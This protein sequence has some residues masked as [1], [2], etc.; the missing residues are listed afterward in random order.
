MDFEFLKGIVPCGTS[1]ASHACTVCDFYVLIQNIINF[2]LFMLAPLATLAAVYIAFLFLFSGGSPAKIT[3]AK[4]K[5]WLVVI[6]IFWVLG[7]W[8][9]LNTIINL[10]ANPSAFPWPWNKPNCEVSQPSSTSDGG[11]SGGGDAS[12]GGAFGGAG[13]SGTWEDAIQTD[14]P[15]YQA[16]DSEHVGLEQVNPGD[17]FSQAQIVNPTVTQIVSQADTNGV[18]KNLV[19][20]IIQAESSG[21]TNAIHLDKDGQSSYGLMQVR[22]DT[23][24]LYDQSLVGLTGA[25]IG[26]KLKNPDY[27]IQIGT[28]YL[29]DLASKYGGDL[30]KVI[31]AYNGG[32]GANKASVDCPGLMRWQCQWDNTAQTIPNTGYAVTRDYVTK[33]NDYYSQLSQ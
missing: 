1:Y 12:D 25:Q 33:V 32:P 27:N 14:T 16:I 26:E 28:A 9:V 5:L 18:N 15:G 29:Q 19:D 30:N 24:K 6:G 23:A 31:A 10:V 8:L 21:N 3:D 11:A 20:A 17:P 13:A 22:P 4:G 7:S 2:F